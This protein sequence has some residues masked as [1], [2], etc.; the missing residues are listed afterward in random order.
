M[1][2]RIGDTSD[3][4]SVFC[5]SEIHK[6]LFLDAFERFACDKAAQGDGAIGRRGVVDFE[7]NGFQAAAKTLNG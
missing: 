1:K 4:N 6:V 3:I 5:P 2:F 7:P